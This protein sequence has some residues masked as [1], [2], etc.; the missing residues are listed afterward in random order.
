MKCNVA[1][2]CYHGGSRLVP[3][4]AAIPGQVIPVERIFIE[5]VVHGLSESPND[6][7]LSPVSLSCSRAVSRSWELKP[8][9]F[10]RANADQE[11]PPARLCYTEAL[12]I[13]HRLDYPI[14][15]QAKSRE[16]VAQQLAIMQKPHAVHILDNECERA[17][18]SQHPIEVPVKV[19]NSRS[20]IANAPLAISLAGVTPYEQ[21]CLWERVESFDI[22]LMQ[23]V[24]FR[25][26]LV[27]PAR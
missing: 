5:S 1:I 13:Q 20:R 16:L 12:G 26:R 25:D 14:A 10:T 19:V 17:D 8:R 2:S 27:E 4:A 15:S 6:V 18:L 24:I 3:L 9:S 7:P 23:A 11:Q 22:T 21:I